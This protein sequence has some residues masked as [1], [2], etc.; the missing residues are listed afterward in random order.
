MKGTCKFILKL[1][2]LSKGKT[3]LHAYFQV[4][5]CSAVSLVFAILCEV[6]TKVLCIF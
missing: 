3:V 1:L 5:G 2:E 6:K 4:E